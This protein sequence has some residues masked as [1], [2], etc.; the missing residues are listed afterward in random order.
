MIKRKLKKLF[1]TLSGKYGHLQKGISCKSS[2]YG[3]NYGGFYVCPDIIS[4]HSI[5]YSFGI[6]E[7]ISFDQA[8]IK[9]HGCNVFAFDPT[10]KSI[11]WLHQQK[12]PEKFLFH[13]YGI[14]EKDAIVDFYLP[15][16]PNYVSGSSILQNNID[17]N[18]KIK[19]P[20]KSIE[21]IINELGHKQIDVLKIDVEGSEYAIIDSLLNSGTRINQILI[22]FH[23]RFFENGRLMTMSAIEKLNKN[24][25]EIFA[26]SDTF[27]E[28]SFI[29]K[30]VL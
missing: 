13:E 17:T 15:K 23:D 18:E 30:N 3:N 19:V 7:D 8:I 4:E 5:I 25:F 9:N 21:S 11:A 26:V 29:N 22:E 16:N 20:L 27:E 28:V 2:W 14:G 24:G 6:G 12:L 1:L 10:P